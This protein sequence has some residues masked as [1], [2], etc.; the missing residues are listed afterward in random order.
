MSNLVFHPDT[1]LCQPPIIDTDLTVSVNAGQYI[2]NILGSDLG[3]NVDRDQKSTVLIVVESDLQL[4]ARYLDKTQ[5][6]RVDFAFLLDCDGQRIGSRDI[7]VFAQ[8]DWSFDGF[9]LIRSP[10]LSPGSHKLHLG[11]QDRHRGFKITFKNIRVSTSL[12]PE[13]K[14][15]FNL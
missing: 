11:I 12:Q 15:D 13:F 3:F 4:E 9:T 1:L 7:I 10:A 6:D 5:I 2:E 8:E 14:F